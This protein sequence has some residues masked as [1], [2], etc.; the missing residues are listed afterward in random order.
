MEMT[1]SDFKS[2]TNSNKNPHCHVF[3]KEVPLLKMY[4]VNRVHSQIQSVHEQQQISELIKYIM[5]K[6][7]LNTTSKYSMEIQIIPIETQ[8]SYET[9]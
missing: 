8:L 7:S 5:Y 4:R 2:F 6:L 1:K 3:F 9:D